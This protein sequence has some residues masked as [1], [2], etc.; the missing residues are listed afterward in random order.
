[1]FYKVSKKVHLTPRWIQPNFIPYLH[2]S[3]NACIYM[4][5]IR[6]QITDFNSP[7]KLTLYPQSNCP[8]DS[9]R[10]LVTISRYPRQYN[11]TLYPRGDHSRETS[12]IGIRIVNGMRAAALTREIGHH[13]GPKREK[14]LY[15]L[16]SIPAQH[17]A[18]R[19]NTP[20]E[21]CQPGGPQR[22]D[23]ITVPL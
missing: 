9:R 12:G 6:Q 4:H 16:R 1:M 11:I 2:R 15:L 18:L 23:G 13:S 19:Y 8:S 14:V 20:C 7:T 10:C 21:T 22:H 17:I 3:R 5:G